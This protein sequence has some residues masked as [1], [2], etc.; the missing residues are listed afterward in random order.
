[1][2]AKN[3]LSI[4]EAMYTLPCGFKKAFSQLPLLEHTLPVQGLQ[5]Q[6]IT[7]LAFPLSSQ[8]PHYIA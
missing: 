2:T 7:N 8:T 5:L 3:G 4:T 6:A 1:M